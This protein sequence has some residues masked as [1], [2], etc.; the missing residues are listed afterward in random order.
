ML[1]FRSA[2]LSCAL[3]ALSIGPG[4]ATVVQYSDLATW[5]AA[6]ASGYTTINFDN[7]GNQ[8]FTTGLVI[9]DGT[10][11]VGTNGQLWA[12]TQ[13][14]G[15]SNTFNFGSGTILEGPAC[16]S[17][18]ITITLPTSSSFTSV[19]FDI[20]TGHSNG[21]TASGISFNATLNNSTFVYTSTPTLPW[22]YPNPTR[23]FFGFT[24][25]VDSPI[26]KLILSL[27][28]SASGVSPFIDNFRY[29]DAAATAAPEACTLLLIGSGLIGMSLFRRRLRRV[30][31]A[32]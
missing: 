16:C 22:S 19:G 28:T 17:G 10:T 11:F 3:L 21:S 25:T 23:A 26:T 8:Q 9:G 29:G 24:T 20:M 27:P 30:A 14:P 12:D 32:V 18:N 6:T 13:S 15:P 2:R 1:C 7:L 4:F 31:E 5:Q